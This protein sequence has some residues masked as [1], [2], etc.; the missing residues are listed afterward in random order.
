MKNKVKNREVLIKISQFYRNIAR[1]N[2]AD[3]GHVL[4]GSRPSGINAV[5]VLERRRQNKWC[6][7]T[8]LAKK[9]LD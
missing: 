2:M 5:S 8:R 9:E 7:N 1:Q 3:A 4:R 6:R